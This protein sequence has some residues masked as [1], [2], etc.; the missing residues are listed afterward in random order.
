MPA[1]PRNLA[2]RPVR[3]DDLDVWQFLVP[4]PKQ[5]RCAAMGEDRAAVAGKDSGPHASLPVYGT[6]ADR[7]GASKDGLQIAGRNPI[8]DRVV[9]ESELP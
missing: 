9:A 5:L 6:V 7:K 4:E 2:S 1:D 8:G 3:R